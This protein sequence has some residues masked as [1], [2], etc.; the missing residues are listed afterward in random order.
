MA[1]AME[2]AHRSGDINAIK[3]VFAGLSDNVSLDR[4]ETGATRATSSSSLRQS[5][6]ELRA[7]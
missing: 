6:A 1:W 3:V 4:R 2:T 5:D 7:C